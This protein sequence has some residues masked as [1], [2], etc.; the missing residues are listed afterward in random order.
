MVWIFTTTC[1]AQQTM[2]EEVEDGSPSRNLFDPK[3]FRRE[4]DWPEC[5]VLFGTKG[6]STTRDSTYPQAAERREVARPLLC[7]AGSAPPVRKIRAAEVQV[8]PLVSWVMAAAI[9]PG[10]GNLLPHPAGIGST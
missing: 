10:S 4:P 2:F 1:E 7:A 5:S 8:M 3:V 9:G 6:S